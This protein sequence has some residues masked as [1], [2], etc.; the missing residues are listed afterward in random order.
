MGQTV[1]RAIQNHLERCGCVPTVFNFQNT[2]GRTSSTLHKEL[3]VSGINTW[4]SGLVQEV[5]KG[6]EDY[7]IQA[8]FKIFCYNNSLYVELMWLIER[9]CC[10][11]LIINI[12]WWTDFTISF[13]LWTLSHRS[14]IEMK[15]I[16]AKYSHWNINEILI[17]CFKSTPFINVCI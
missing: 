13:M 6:T 2:V 14:K 10:N 17:Y 15:Q 16:S 5:E 1:L 9:L 8:H 7:K 11:L 12:L 4:E 3:R